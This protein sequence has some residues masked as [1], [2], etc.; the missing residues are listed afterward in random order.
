MDVE[1]VRSGDGTAITVETVGSGPPLVLTVGAFCDRATTRVL[2]ERLADV[3]TVHAFDRRGRGD[4]DAP[5]TPPFARDAETAD[6]LAVLAHAASPGAAPALYGHSSG[7]VLAAEAAFTGVPL[8]ALALYE[9]PWRVDDDLVDT[10]PLVEEMQSLVAQGRPG[11]A[12]AL[13]L[14]VATG[15]DDETVEQMRGMPFW[16]GLEALAPTLPYDLALVGEGRL[17]ADRLAALTPPVLVM[18]GG[19]SAAWARRSVAALAAT[20]PGARHHC[21][22][23]QDHGIDQELLAPVLQEFLTGPPGQAAAS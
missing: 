19:R 11:D 13:F 12:A 14:I 22:A 23:T 18:D 3:F 16:G 5:A 1:Q 10:V 21:F 6:L 7:A 2:A 20:V 15:A 4:S 9:P 8:A 17:P